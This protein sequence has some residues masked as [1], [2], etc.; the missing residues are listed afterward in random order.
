MNLETFRDKLRL[1]LEENRFTNPSAHKALSQAG[2]LT[3]R[4]TFYLNFKD[5][6]PPLSEVI[7]IC[8][9]FGVSLDSICD[10]TGDVARSGKLDPKLE[11][12][13]NLVKKIGPDTVLEI[14]AGVTDPLERQSRP[15]A[16]RTEDLRPIDGKLE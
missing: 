12:V 10:E 4:A 15:R 9:F 13:M 2:L 14:L 11:I 3:K 1:L 7:T 16:L 5:R 8:K 6:D